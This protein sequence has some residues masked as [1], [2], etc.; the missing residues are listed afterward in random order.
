[1]NS[2][3]QN[4]REFLLLFEAVMTNP[5]GDPDQENMPRM[6][7]E[8]G[9]LLVSDVRRKRDVREMLKLKG[10]RIF[11]DTLAD[12]KVPM[13][14]M[15]DHIVKGVL[16]SPEK[17]KSLRDENPELESSWALGKDPSKYL[18]VYET[19]SSSKTKA[20]DKDKPD[21]PTFKSELIT[22][23]I[24]S[25]LIDIRLFGSAMAI[26]KVSRTFTGPIQMNWGYSLH[27]CQLCKS[28]T[29]TSIMNDDSST[30][31]KK[32]QVEY[33]LVAHYGTVNKFNAQKTGMKEGD[34]DLFRKAMVQGM[35]NNQ[36]A[37][38][39]GQN[40]LMYLEIEYGDSFDGYLGD[41]RR[42]IDVSYDRESPVK[43]MEDV[44]VDFAR[45]F[46]VIEDMKSKGYVKGVKS[47]IHPFVTKDVFSGM[48]KSEE[49]DLWKQ[50]D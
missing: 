49:I 20:K 41:L 35:M 37:S 50:I 5:N 9:T 32:H 48:S 23:I 12:R 36:T 22:A 42:F 44:K 10:Y 1:M 13:D 4:N 25:E 6:D 2:R 7:F 38:K 46:E 31:G 3:V 43:K 17:I 28:N 39:S 40:P 26:D 29:I 27:P 30:F 24:K 33:A 8:T 11:V 45:L 19:E 15:F 34:V 21:F 16:S 18:E 14:V 47:W